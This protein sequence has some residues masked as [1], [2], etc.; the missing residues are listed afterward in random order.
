MAFAES[1]FTRSSVSPDFLAG[2]RRPMDALSGRSACCATRYRKYSRSRDWGPPTSAQAGFAH[3]RGPPYCYDRS[4]AFPRGGRLTQPFS[5]AVKCSGVSSLYRWRLVIC[6]F[7]I[8]YL[9]LYASCVFCLWRINVLTVHTFS[10]LFDPVIFEEQCQHDLHKPSS[11]T[12]TRH[13]GL[14]RI[15][16]LHILYRSIDVFVTKIQN[17]VCR[18]VKCHI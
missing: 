13:I 16:R 3:D 8:L 9:C 12:E 2:L 5:V 11:F 17:G 6:W 15:D 4:C 7:S 18:H 1:D 14:R 10:R